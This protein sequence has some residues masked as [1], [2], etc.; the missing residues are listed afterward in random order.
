MSNHQN[1][2]ILGKGVT[3]FKGIFGT[4]IDLHKKFKNKSYFETSIAKISCYRWSHWGI[5]KWNYIQ[6][7]TY[8][9]SRFWTVTF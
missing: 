4:T 6:I 3:D 2:M 9:K 7:N 1:T 8:I 5:F